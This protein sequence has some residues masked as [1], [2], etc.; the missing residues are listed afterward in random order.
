MTGDASVSFPSVPRHRLEREGWELFDESV[1]TVFRLPGLSVVGGTRLFRDAATARAARDAA[2]VDAVWRFF[3]ATALTFDPSLPESAARRL[4]SPTV[5]ARATER[6][7]SDLRDRGLSGVR[8]TGAERVRVAAGGRVS[9]AR[10]RAALDPDG[11]DATVPVTA[12]IGV[13]HADG[14][15]VAAGAYPDRRVADALALADP[16]AVLARDPAEYRAELF[17]LIAAVE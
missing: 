1:E 17:E 5:R 2:G 4:L 9:L 15:R 7:G 16:P 14:F 6:F 10:F 12:W 11:T 8:R 13:W 3:F